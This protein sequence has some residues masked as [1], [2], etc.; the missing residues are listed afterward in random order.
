MA[1]S[2][3]SLVFQGLLLK[4]SYKII[5][6][7]SENLISINIMWKVIFLIR[8]YSI[9]TILNKMSPCQSEA[10]IFITRCGKL[11]NYSRNINLRNEIKGSILFEKLISLEALP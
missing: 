5:I 8:N 3:R 1:L 7:S 2:I 6:S 11:R 10:I 4:F 9:E